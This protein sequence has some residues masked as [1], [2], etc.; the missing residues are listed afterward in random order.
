[1]K[2]AKILRRKYFV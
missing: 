1:V 2:F